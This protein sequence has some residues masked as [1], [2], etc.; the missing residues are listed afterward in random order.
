VRD[1][2]RSDDVSRWNPGRYHKNTV[3]A[4]CGPNY[5]NEGI[6]SVAEEHSKSGDHNETAR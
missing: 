4:I 5:S 2:V 1:E 3:S 6:P